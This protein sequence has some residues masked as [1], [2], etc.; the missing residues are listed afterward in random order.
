MAH[1]ILTRFARNS[2]GPERETEFWPPALAGREPDNGVVQC[3]VYL[4]LGLDAEQ[5]SVGG[6]E[7]LDHILVCE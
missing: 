6:D 5:G 2:I 3:S 1:S 4:V 7:C